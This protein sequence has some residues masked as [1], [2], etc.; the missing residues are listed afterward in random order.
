VGTPEQKF[1]I[2]NIQASSK[3]KRPYATDFQNV[4]YCVPP[5]VVKNKNKND[6]PTTEKAKLFFSKKCTSTIYV[7]FVLYYPLM[8]ILK[9]SKTATILI[10]L[11]YYKSNIILLAVTLNNLT[12]E[13]NFYVTELIIILETSHPTS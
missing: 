5:V 13:G 8:E 1:T 2:K 7:H 9:S 4:A 3:N 11:Y 6:I 12:D 10:I